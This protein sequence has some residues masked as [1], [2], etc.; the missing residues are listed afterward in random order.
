[1]QIHD[2]MVQILDTIIQ[3]LD[4]MGCVYVSRHLKFESLIYSDWAAFYGLSQ[5]FFAQIIQILK[6]I[7]IF[8]FSSKLGYFYRF[9]T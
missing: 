7:K 3:I 9:F 6:R 4:T 1:M 5:Q 2:T 8:H